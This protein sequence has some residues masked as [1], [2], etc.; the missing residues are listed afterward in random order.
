LVARADLIDM[1]EVDV[2]ES[3]AAGG[4]AVRGGA[5]RVLGYVLTAVLGAGSAAV[6]FR[7][8]GVRGT[9][10]YITVLSIIAIVGGFSDLGLTTLGLRE[11]AVRDAAARRELM[12]TLLGLRIEVTTI[13][14][15]VGVAFAVV[16]GY[17]SPL[18]LGVAVGGLA[19]L[20]QNLQTTL[21]IDLLR[22]LRFG[23]VTV[24]E[25]GRQVVL[26]VLVIVLALSGAGLVVIIAASVPAALASLLATAVLV[27]GNIA[28]RPAFRRAERLALL[29]DLLPFA[30][31]IATAALYFRASVVVVSLASSSLQL[32]YFSAS[33]RIIEVLIQI[34]ALMAGAA[35]PIFARAARDNHVRFAY[36]A[37]RVFE[38][39]AIVGVLFALLLALGAPV[40]IDIVGGAKFH[41][42]IDVVRIQALGL[43]GS[44]VSAVW[45][46]VLLSLRMQ[47]ELIVINLAA[48]AGGV[49]LVA[50][51]TSLAGADGAAGATAATELSLAVVG[52]LAL[53]RRHPN[54]VPSLRRLPR[55]LVAGIGAAS[56]ALVPGLPA[57]AQ[58]AAAAVIYVG[59]LFALHA[60]PDEVRAEL[61]RLR[62][63]AGSS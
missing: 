55:T 57:L 48:L 63:R 19:L 9:G 24:F 49:V 14:V 29:R 33:F 8:L 34:P 62:P 20:I 59:L 45:G 46:Y 50:V 28:T 47:R 18:V 21:A 61:L 17:R 37:E 2:L 32:G 38:V 52:G 53:A 15:G 11:L 35:F 13:S 27:R 31:A 42:A 4:A 5:L 16:A 36:G 51:L 3:S 58:V 43:G 30:I 12:R 54:L 6:V 23:W 26:A 40:A 44:F 7:H 25:V 1:A 22:N 39:A 60:V 10:S 41:P 56:V